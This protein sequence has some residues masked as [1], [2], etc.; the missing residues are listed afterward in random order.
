MST[1][2]GEPPR[3][4]RV[5]NKTTNSLNHDEHDGHNEQ[6]IVRLQFA[7]LRIER[8]FVV[9][10]VSLWFSSFVGGP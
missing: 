7:A 8:K 1:D 9:F 4:F 6:Q 10:V 2:R 3:A 5:P